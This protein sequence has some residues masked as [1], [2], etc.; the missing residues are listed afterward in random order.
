LILRFGCK[1]ISCQGHGFPNNCNFD[2][3]KRWGLFNSGAD[4][5]VLVAMIKVVEAMVSKK[6]YF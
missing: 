5:K 6:L 4:F 1:G 3:E 2:L